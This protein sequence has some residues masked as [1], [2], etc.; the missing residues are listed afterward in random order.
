V[1]QGVLLLGRVPKIRPQ[2]P[3]AVLPAAFTHW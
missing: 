2:N 1:S 3:Q